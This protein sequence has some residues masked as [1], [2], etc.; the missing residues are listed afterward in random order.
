M[1]AEQ[2]R[3]Q[4]RT[5]AAPTLTLSPPAQP[6]LSAGAQPDREA[7]ESIVP[8]RPRPPG[9]QPG[10]DLGGMMGQL[11]SQLGGGAGGSQAGSGAGTVLCSH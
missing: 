2:N 7:V 11:M 4:P 3:P 8:A 1:Q 10:G 9:F 5:T 6:Q